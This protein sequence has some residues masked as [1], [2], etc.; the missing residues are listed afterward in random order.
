[1]RSKRFIFLIFI[2]LTATIITSCVDRVVAKKHT[3]DILKMKDG[4]KISG[5]IVQD[6]Q[7][8]PFIQIVES[9]SDILKLVKRSKINIIG[10]ADLII[11]KNEELITGSFEMDII[12]VE[13]A[14][15]ENNIIE[16]ETGNIKE[17]HFNPEGNDQI[18]KNNNE[19]VIGKIL[20]E[21]LD[22]VT[23]AGYRAIQKNQINMIIM[24]G[25]VK[26]EEQNIEDIW[27]EIVNNI[28][29]HNVIPKSTEGRKDNGW[30]Y[31]LIGVL[32]VFAALILMV[33]A[34][35][36]MKYVKG[37]KD[38]TK[39]KKQDK[40]AKTTQKGEL[41][42]EIVTAIA[43]TLTL[44]EGGEKL[45]LTFDRNKTSSYNWA[46]SGRMDNAQRAEFQ[47]GW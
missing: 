11:L 24:R 42:E 25:T 27:N 14:D 35:L 5:V 15:E 30:L 7:N 40:T 31:T 38:K 37:N 19:K 33:I 29:F 13:K 6:N 47:R 3:A 2:L 45:R 44:H 21:K 8:S 39:T 10:Y 4:T 41:P 20:D 1:M 22:V 32:V 36:L 43:L 12:K 16:V 17:V 46:Y 23:K 18:V 28:G 9:S 26:E 34:F